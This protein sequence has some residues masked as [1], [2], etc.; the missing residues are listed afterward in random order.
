MNANTYKNLE[1]L[2]YGELVT[3]LENIKN[4]IMNSDVLEEK[5][6]VSISDANYYN[7][8]VAELDK[9]QKVSV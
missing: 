3:A 1:E 7:A 2:S 4:K 8:L 5:G 6:T 9:R